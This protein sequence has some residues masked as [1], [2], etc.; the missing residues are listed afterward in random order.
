MNQNLY[1]ITTREAGELLTDCFEAGL[2]PMLTSDP[3]MGKSALYAA[4]AKKFSLKLIDL[5]LSTLE[6]VDL[7]GMV[8]ISGQKATYKPFDVFP[9][10]KDP[11]PT[12]YQGWLVLLDEL[13]SASRDLIAAAYKLVLDHAVGQ[14][15]LHPK[16]FIAGAGNK[17][18]SRAI[19]NEMGTAMNSRLIHL[20]LRTDWQIFFEDVAVPLN[21]DSRIIA[22]LAMYNHLLSNFDPESNEKT[23][24]CPRTWEFLSRIINGKSVTQE[25]IAL[26]AGVIGQ[27]VAMQFVDFCN[28][29]SKLV[30]F[31]QIVAD[32]QNCSL[33]DE[34]A[35]RWA[36]VTMV[37]ERVKHANFGQCCEYISRFPAEFMILFFQGVKSRDQTL[38]Q[39]P[40]FMKNAS[41]IA[42]YLFGDK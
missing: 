17:E 38:L 37:L 14:Y 31:E 32:P 7:T 6:S 3:G 20:E 12:G 35:L 41:K 24:A 2:V 40:A 26:Y 21:F 25:K 18:S 13:N 36:T 8:D 39:H 5:R 33:P 27:G 15:K 11:I 4:L 1:T 28:V 22:F 42:T 29:Y 10:E 23:F 30:T 34:T 19:V 9:L 16:C